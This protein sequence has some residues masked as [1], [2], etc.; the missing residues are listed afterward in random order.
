MT[1]TANYGKRSIS[2]IHAKLRIKCSQLS[3]Q[4][5][6]MHIIENSACYMKTNFTISL[7]F[8]QEINCI[9]L[10]LIYRLTVGIYIVCYLEINE[11]S[12]EQNEGIVKAVHDFITETGG[13]VV[14][15]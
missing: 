3:V 12:I 2:I 4:L 15:I 11:L 6:D 9:T 13:F 10:L 1:V 5:Y 7:I 8:L 14:Y